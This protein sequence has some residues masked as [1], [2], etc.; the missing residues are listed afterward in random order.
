MNHEATH[1]TGSRQAAHE[2]GRQH[3]RHLLVM[4]FLSFLA[5]Y[6]LMYAMV[7]RL[8]NA[9]ANLNQAYMAA[10]MAAPM[11]IIELLVMR[12][13]YRDARAN[14]TWITAS[15]LVLVGCFLLIRA[16]AGIGD[17]QFVRS[18]IPH[19][20]GAILMCEQASLRDPELKALCEQI[21]A[22]QQAEID[23]MKAILKTIDR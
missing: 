19:H 4:A 5:M 16:Q 21:R 20:A 13:M 10:L 1:E 18:M 23:Q 6:V 15:A 3:Y 14:A 2:K 17:R 22:S 11:V 7:D 12:A 9:Y 8:A